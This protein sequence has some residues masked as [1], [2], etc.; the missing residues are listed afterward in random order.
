MKRMNVL[1][2]TMSRIL[3]MA[4]LCMLSQGTVALPLMRTVMV[5]V[6]MTWGEDL[7]AAAPDVK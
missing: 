3:H 1:Q 7:V 6:L 5:M 4:A 2:M